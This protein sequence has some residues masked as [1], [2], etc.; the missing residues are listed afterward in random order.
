MPKG[1]IRFWQRLPPIPSIRET[2]IISR[3]TKGE[4]VESSPLLSGPG[5]DEG[6]SPQM[7]LWVFALTRAMN[8]Q[9]SFSSA[10]GL[11][12]R[13]RK[14]QEK[15]LL[16]R[17]KRAHEMLSLWFKRLFALFCKWL[18]V[19][20]RRVLTMI[21]SISGR[22]PFSSFFL[23]SEAAP[24]PEHKKVEGG[25]IQTYNGKKKEEEEAFCRMEKVSPFHPISAGRR[26]RRGRRMK[27][28]E[29][30]LKG[31]ALFYVHTLAA[32]T[33]SFMFPPFHRPSSPKFVAAEASPKKL[34]ERRR[35][36]TFSR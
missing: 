34:L 2:G 18:V 16:L 22:P 29:G 27:V 32:L 12:D 24:G 25:W 9:S 6:P 36:E 33:L 10:I 1:G 14:K 28:Y 8:L 20:V 21:F 3:Y 7:Y 19:C 17:F 11:P 31:L 15:S 30:G 4:K 13:E 26:R 5:S 35:K 23:S